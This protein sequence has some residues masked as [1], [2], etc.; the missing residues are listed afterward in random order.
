MIHDSRDTWG[1][2]TRALH[3]I[4][5]M[6]IVGMF[7]LGWTAVNYPMSPTKLEL[8]LWHKSIGLTLF[9]LVLFRILWRLTNETPAKPTGVSASEQQLARIGHVT[10]YLL[11]ILMPVSGYIVNSTANFSFRYF[12]GGQVPNLIPADKAWQDVAETVHL[13]A[14]WIF[15]T[16]I[17]IHVLAA[18]RHHFFK[19]NDTLKKMLTGAENPR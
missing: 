11:M 5:A 18:F 6:L 10:L 16:V 12:G 3:W 13:A 1:S 19:K 9:A 17:L 8:F 14:F 4:M 2:V 15:A 7:V